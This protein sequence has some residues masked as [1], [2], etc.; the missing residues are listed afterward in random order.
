MTTVAVMQPYFIPYAGY[1]RLFAAADVVVMFDCV[2]FPRRGWVHRNR[3]PISAD[4]SGWFTL[5]IDKARREA[6]ISEITFP[7]DVR[8]RIETAM[9]RFP[10][11][12]QARRKGN[13]L[14]DRL[15]PLAGDEVAG[16][17]SGLVADFTSLLGLERT[18][19]RSSTLGIP[20]ELKAQDRII[21]IAQR[22]GA[23]RYVNPSGGRKLYDRATFAGAG[24]DLA[25]L[26]PYGGNMQSI[27]ARLLAEPA[28]AV[29]AEILHE[30][31]LVS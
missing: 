29:K 4:A 30:T 1:F 10:L 24:L 21:A 8:A 17:L 31:T 22:L 14:L 15:L 19:L 20:A 18:M 26:T 11:L 6:L 28:R 16:Y 12:V 3:L 5:P 9:L 13:P 25:F 7:P 27:L 2:Q 23:T